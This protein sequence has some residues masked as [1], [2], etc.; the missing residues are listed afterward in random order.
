MITQNYAAVPY[1]LLLFYQ[2]R[3]HD[4]QSPVLLNMKCIAHVMSKQDQWTFIYVVILFCHATEISLE[5]STHTS[6]Y[7]T[8]SS[9]ELSIHASC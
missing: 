2:E 8:V 6:C 7:A 9:L 4:F 3:T 5:L 1:L